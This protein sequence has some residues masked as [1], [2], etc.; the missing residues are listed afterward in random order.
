[1][2]NNLVGVLILISLLISGPWLIKSDSLVVQ[3]ADSGQ[4]IYQQQVSPELNFAI[5][6]THSVENTPVWDYFKVTKGQLFLTS[7]KYMSY[8]AG[9]PFLDKNDYVVE[10]GQFIIKDI[11]TKLE[12]I[13]LR[14]SDYAK[15]KLLIN[16]QSYKL[17]KMTVPQTLVKIRVVEQ[18]YYQLLLWEVR[19]WWRKKN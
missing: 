3:N 12:Q 10:E 4:V 17:Y 6:Y 1:M 9:L 11:D 14:V 18:N 7:T 16:G 8:G 15:H 13:P 5:K 19:R 2:K